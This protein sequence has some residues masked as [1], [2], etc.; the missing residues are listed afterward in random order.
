MRWLCGKKH[1]WD[2]RKCVVYVGKKDDGV[3]NTCVVDVCKTSQIEPGNRMGGLEIC[4]IP[5]L[6]DWPVKIL[7][8]EYGV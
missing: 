7:F 5:V 3:I 8:G 1:D 2:I 4:A 6:W